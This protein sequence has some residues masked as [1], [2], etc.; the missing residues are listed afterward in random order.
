LSP[1]IL[2]KIRDHIRVALTY[3]SNAIEGNTL[4]LQETAVVLEGQTIGGKPLRDHLEAIDHAAAF[5]YVWDLAARREALTPHDVRAIHALVTR[6]TL[7]QGSGTWRAVGVRITGSPHQPPDAIHVP[8]LMEDWVNRFN[9][10]D[11]DHPLIRAARLHAEFVTIHPFLDGNGRTARLITNLDL[12]RQGYVPALLLP[13]DRLAYY[14]ALEAARAGS[15]D[16][17]IQ[18]LALA[19]HRTFAQFWLPYLQPAPTP[20]RPGPTL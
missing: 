17:L 1:D 13:Q 5:D 16:P 2:A 4:T 19:V 7:S 6:N 11:S 15:W 12:I 8:H 9:R 3:T 20:P 14:Q 10:P 18:H